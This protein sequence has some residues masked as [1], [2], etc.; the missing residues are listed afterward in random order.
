M[1]L[2]LALA[3]SAP[4]PIA[5]P[6][7]DWKP[8]LLERAFEFDAD[9]AGARNSVAAAKRSG[10]TAECV[11]EPQITGQVTFTFQKKGGPK[12]TIAGHPATPVVVRGD[13]LYVADFQGASSGCKVVAYDLT[14]GKK[15]WTKEL[16]GLGP[17][18]H[19][20]YRNRVAMAVE[21]HPTQNH[22]ALVIVG[23]E[24]AGRYVEVLD[25]VSG[26]QLA[27]KKYDRDN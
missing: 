7:A 21:K 25:P 13:G 17:I 23:W 2:A 14:T 4:V 5:P 8:A 24:S 19:S 26:K 11:E 3:A 6:T 22:F 18:D 16:E 27:H 1:F 20:K 15:A 9:H 10:L 12:L